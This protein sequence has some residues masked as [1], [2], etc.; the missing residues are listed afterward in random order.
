MTWTTRPRSDLPGGLAAIRQGQGAPVILIHGVGLTADSWGGQ[1]DALADR[2]SVIA[3]DLPGHGASAPLPAGAGLGDW[4]EALAAA[5]ADFAPPYRLAGHSLGALL[6]LHMA[7]RHPDI[8]ARAAMLNTIHRR[9]PEAS[10]AVQARAAALS[11]QSAGDP[12]P[13]L[14]RW[15]GAALDSAPARACRTWL[16]AVDPSAYARAYS[17]FAQADSPPDDELA[18]LTCPALFLT[19]GAEPNSTPA[20]SRALAELTPNGRA[21]IIPNAAHMAMMSHIDAVNRALLDFF[22]DDAEASDHGD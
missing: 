9:A 18:S 20:M 7:V 14:E 11:G 3:V 22:T 2:F 10:A 8:C 5:I 4:V 1:I 12:T 16:E 17:L 19:G 15:F 6:T 21:L 13:T